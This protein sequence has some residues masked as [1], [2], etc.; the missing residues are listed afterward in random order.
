[1][2]ETR[3]WVEKWQFGVYRKTDAFP[4]ET[5]FGAIQKTTDESSKAPNLIAV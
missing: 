2:V 5:L 4:K 1:V 3:I